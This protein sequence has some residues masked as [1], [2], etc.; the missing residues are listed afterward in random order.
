VSS[1][2]RRGAAPRSAAG[3]ALIA[4][5]MLLA[6]LV[7]IAGPFLLSTAL[8]E[9]ESRLFAARS[10]ARIAAEGA[11]SRALW[12]LSRTSDRAER[13][14]LY[15]FPF[16]TPDYDTL[17][18]LEVSFTFREPPVPRGQKP[19]RLPPSLA[20]PPGGGSPPGFLNP[21]GE[22]WKAEIEDEQGKIN[23]NSAT[24]ALLGNL[25]GS[26]ILQLPLGPGAGEPSMTVS[27]T[28][29]F[30]ADGDDRTV[31]GFVRVG[32]EIIAYRSK[33]PT[34][35]DGL[36]R[37]CF[38]TEIEAHPPGTLVFDARA[39]A[40]AAFKLIG[41]AG[42]RPLARFQ[43]VPAIG[44]ISEL[45][46]DAQTRKPLAFEPE[47]F[48]SVERCLTAG[49]YRP[50]ADGWVRR[51]AIMGGAFD[52]DRRDFILRDNSNFGPGTVVRFV[53][54]SGQLRGY[55]RVFSAQYRAQVSPAGASVRLEYGCGFSHDGNSEMFMEAELPHAINVNT[56]PLPVLA[57]CMTGLALQ[58]GGS[59][60]SPESAALVANRIAN[61]VVR[62]E[63]GRDV[64]AIRNRED[65]DAVLTAACSA[66]D[67][68]DPDRQAILENATV[69]GSTRLRVT[70]APFCF[71]A[72]NLFTVEASAAVNS[73]TSGRPLA[74]HT[75]RE[76]VQ[77]PSDPRGVFEV[78]SQK[79]FEEQI[80]FGV[81]RKVNTWPNW[82]GF[83]PNNNV[84]DENVAP[85]IGDVRLATGRSGRTL[86]GTVFV[87]HFDANRPGRVLTPDGLTLQGQGLAFPGGFATGA[88]GT[89]PGSAEAWFASPDWAGSL[90][91]AEGPGG[92]LLNV[93]YERGQQHELVM[94]L[95]DGTMNAGDFPT[96][97]VQYRQPFF[98]GGNTWYHIRA[99]YKSSRLG[100][101]A[102]QVD[103]GMVSPSG[104][105]RY[106]PMATLTAD[107]DDWSTKKLTD[108]VNV[109][110]DDTGLF[111]AY[112]AFIIDG[113]IFEY[114]SKDGK[115][116]LNARRGRRYTQP[117]AH[118]SGAAVQIYGYSVGVSTVPLVS[119]LL[120]EPVGANPSTRI[121]KPGSAGPPPV[122]AG[123][124]DTVTTIPVLSTA[125]FQSS[126]YLWCDQECI[127]Y[128]RISA[129][130]FLDCV[131][132]QLAGPAAAHAHNAGIAQIS[133]KVTNYDNYPDQGTV[134]IDEVNSANNVEWIDY[135][136]KRRDPAG[137]L[138]L[139]ASFYQNPTTHVWYRSFTRGSH[140]SGTRAH[141]K[142][143]KIL[144]VFDI[145]GPNCGDT[146]SP[147][148]EPVTIANPNGDRE[149]HRLKR[150]WESTWF[151]TDINGRYT[152]YGHSFRA[153]FDDF[154]ARD[155]RGARLL[156]FPSGELPTRLVVLQAGIG[157]QGFIDEVRACTG[158]SQNG[159]L[160]VD[161]RDPAYGRLNA[162]STNV[163]V[164]MPSDAA[165]NQ[166]PATGGLARIGDELFY[167]QGRTLG[168]QTPPAPWTPRL[169]FRNPTPGI[170]QYDGAPDD[171]N[172]TRRNVPVVTL[173]N[174]RRA[175]LGSTGA[176]HAPGEAVTFLEA[177]PVTELTGG[178]AGGSA[179]GMTA[180]G[181]DVNV[182]NA[183]GF[184]DEGYLTV[185]AEAIGYTQRANNTLRNGLFRGAFG[186]VGQVHPSGELVQPLPFRYWDR[187]IPENDSSELA[188]VQGG[189]SAAGS[190]WQEMTLDFLGAP[191]R[192]YVLVR[193]DGKP[194]WSARPTN[195]DGGLYAFAG[196]G[197]HVFRT[198]ANR[199]V[200]ADQMEYRILFP[201]SNGDLRNT[202]WKETPVVDRITVRYGNPLVVMRREVSER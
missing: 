3:V 202:A 158:H 48:E 61:W 118:R 63:R 77:M 125:G 129:T 148:Y 46:P 66:R 33:N 26:A 104:P 44:R 191:S 2:S 134:Q 181:V 141:A 108:P 195:S 79:E 137:N 165:A 133:L 95:S 54:A 150:V 15:G 131:R 105:A 183:A 84:P 113:E 71:R 62:D 50:K 172:P 20:P 59:G 173:T 83:A 197:P 110:V 171:S 142:G 21:R 5:I 96:R 23:V 32:R 155:Y 149:P 4:A 73:S 130:E 57:A 199:P 159:S 102:F 85:S 146:A 10:R 114:A 201:F 152:G 94:E 70:T 98:L 16:D 47:K 175:V 135:Y 13:V 184:D 43:S 140:G 89:M 122:A 22:I 186:T 68:T 138:Y 103:G 18:E 111:P 163:L 106:S 37:G 99:A 156:K 11:R 76:L 93:F 200:R 81:G 40:V 51:E 139:M 182:R 53:S 65:L 116:F 145:A 144:P 190:L 196:G 167:Y 97:T 8:E 28:Q 136:Q 185:G 92:D 147:Q 6:G 143:A 80:K 169:P 109:M 24:P 87:E 7:A 164:Q 27:S 60:V 100:G 176:E 74:T 188:C 162:T 36:V 39:W 194:E 86:P 151:N 64:P 189:F 187:F 115:T 49:S 69:P 193:F 45:G 41:A 35:L 161:S 179:G 29:G 112:G 55:G 82:L 19:G 101:Q 56:A 177:F 88:N 38:N 1:R 75:I 198:R 34:T 107:L 25:L 153:A 157:M 124:D 58:G 17:E 42:G 52:G 128:G 14:G 90:F 67:I 72:Y 123:I 127:Y 30:A 192:I 126:G 119:G 91:R 168:R 180:S 9:R 78:R 166:I 170:P 121:N 120:A 31:D 154:V 117:M 174:V 132:G 160:P 178:L 12:C